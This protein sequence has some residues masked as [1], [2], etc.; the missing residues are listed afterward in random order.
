MHAHPGHGADEDK[1][2][3]REVAENTYR[4]DDDPI[5]PAAGTSGFPPFVVV[6]VAG[7]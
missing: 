2:Q 1:Q 3:G 4:A 7:C 5:R 6:V